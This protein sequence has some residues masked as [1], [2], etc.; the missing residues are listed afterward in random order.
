MRDAG[1]GMR[2]ASSTTPPASRIPPPE[3]PE[4]PET[5]K[6]MTA[7]RAPSA[8]P[9]TPHG[10]PARQPAAWVPGGVLNGAPHL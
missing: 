8:T 7:T 1:G 10:S 6:A 4:T 9:A 3:T 5:R 2:D